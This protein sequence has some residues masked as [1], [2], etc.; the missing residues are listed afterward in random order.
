MNPFDYGGTIEFYLS[1]YVE[2]RYEMARFRI[3]FIDS[4]LCGAYCIF[5]AYNLAKNLS[6]KR[7]MQKFSKKTCANDEFIEKFI[8]SFPCMIN[9]CNT[10]N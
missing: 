6:V 2:S 1:S 3:Q 5:I 7:I 10:S 8:L 9:K 4:L